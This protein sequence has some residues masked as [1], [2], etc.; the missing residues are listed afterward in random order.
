[1][2]EVS[3][4][5]SGEA[6]TLSGAILLYGGIAE[7][8]NQYLHR[9]TKFATVHDVQIIA[10]RPEIMP[11]RLLTE[12]DLA[13]IAKGV[14]TA[15]ESV[16]TD[17]IDP[18]VLAKGQDRLIW[19]TAPSKRPMF[20]QQSSYNKDTFTA[21]GV[22][23]VSGLVWVAMPGNGLYVYAVKGS[24]RPEPRTQLYQAPFFNVWGRGKV[25]VGSAAPPTEE[26]KWDT[27]AW[28]RMFFG[29]RFT[30]PN[31]AEKDRLTKGV[32]PTKFWKEMVASPTDAFPEKRLV[33]IPLTVGDLL[34][35]TLLDRLAKLPKPQGEF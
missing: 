26:A 22:C 5:E 17:W 24:D 27:A 28:E 1:M 35:R 19:W 15:S 14:A 33:Q 10:G 7:G 21:N 20:F 34:D 30:H 11:G 3:L 6:A 4:Q 9:G 13:T 2:L 18:G 8:R 12:R 23:P 32:S 25:C 29:S 31:F 16:T